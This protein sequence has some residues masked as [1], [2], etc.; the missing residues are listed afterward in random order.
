MSDVGGV[1]NSNPLAALQSL[2]QP[3]SR[4]SSQ[5]S[6]PEVGRSLRVTPS[7][8]SE[9]QFA[10][11][12]S[13]ATQGVT[14]ARSIDSINFS[15]AAERLRQGQSVASASPTYGVGGLQATTPAA[16]REALST[17]ARQM[18]AA[19]VSQPMDFV[20]GQAPARGGAMP[21]YTNPAIANSVAT[22]T[23]AARVGLSID[24]TG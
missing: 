18:V 17:S 9:A 22:S 11:K 13:G 23:N 5:P 19:Q 4:P 12:L 20:S 8:L 6:S 7:T 15:Q 24:A 10:S 21:F 1:T 2:G 14:Q 3:I 16:A